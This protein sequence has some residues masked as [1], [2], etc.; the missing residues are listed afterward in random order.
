MPA[1]PA[2]S[3]NSSAAIARGTRQRAAIRR[4]FSEAARPLSPKEILTLATRDVPSLGIATVYRNL[5]A[6]LEAGDLIA[7]PVPGQPDRYHPPVDPLP[8]LLRCSR[9]EKVVFLPLPERPPTL[10]V[11][12]GF[13]VDRIDTFAHGHCAGPCQLD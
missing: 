11:P 13:A 6:M 4:A 7:V 3:P 8:P 5:R 2:L 12:A 10:A 1:S 9:C